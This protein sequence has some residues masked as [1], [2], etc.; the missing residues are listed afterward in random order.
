MSAPTKHSASQSCAKVWSQ[1]YPNVGV[2][3]ILEKPNLLSTVLNMHYLAI[4][5]MPTMCMT[6]LEHQVGSQLSRNAMGD[7]Q[8]EKRAPLF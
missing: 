1:N 8:R 5:L 2:V 3:G 7:I 4:N 6:L